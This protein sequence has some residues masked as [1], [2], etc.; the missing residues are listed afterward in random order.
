MHERP[1]SA[2][3]RI[4][5]LG[6]AVLLAMQL[7]LKATLPAPAAAASDLHALPSLPILRLAANGD[8]APLAKLLMLYLQAFDRSA[9]NAISYQALDYDRLIDWLEKIVDLDPAGQ[10]PLHAASRIYAEVP[11]PEKKRK[12]LDLVYRRFFADPDRRWPWLAHAASVA[13]HQL[14]DLPLAQRYAAAL[15]AKAT[16]PAVPL[17]ARQM[18]AFILE[19]MDELE[20][21]RIMIGGFVQS[22]QVKDAGELRFLEQRLQEIEARLALK[23]PPAP[24]P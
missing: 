13:K 7:A 22:G 2:V 24:R 4:V 3:P 5:M 19:D 9:A 1:I 8:P 14:R 23:K 12:M 11:D 10:Y 18:E 20:T 21:A 17:W 15:Q 16:G 6:L